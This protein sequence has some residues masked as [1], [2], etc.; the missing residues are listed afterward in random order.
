M[1]SSSWSSGVFTKRP[2]DFLVE[3][4]VVDVDARVLVAVLESLVRVLDTPLDEALPVTLD[5]GEELVRLD[6]V[7]AL[8]DHAGANRDAKGAI[9]H[10]GDPTSR[11]LPARRVS[12]SPFSSASTSSG[13]TP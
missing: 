3:V 1:R 11:A 7:L 4:G 9:T 12:Q 2:C 5:G 8:H 6:L 10:H 13:V